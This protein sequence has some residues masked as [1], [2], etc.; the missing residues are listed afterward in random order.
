MSPTF[1]P[2]LQVH[3]CSTRRR[4][5]STAGPAS[6][7]GDAGTA[8]ATGEGE[9]EKGERETNE[10]QWGNRGKLIYEGSIAHHVRGLKR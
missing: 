8:A 10:D 5:L 9:I 1:Y 7:G 4:A 3:S 2:H 6:G